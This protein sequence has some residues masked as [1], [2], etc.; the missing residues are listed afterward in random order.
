MGL[1][2]TTKRPARRSDWEHDLGLTATWLHLREEIKVNN[3]TWVLE[4]DF[5]DE[6]ANA[7]CKP[8]AIIISA[9][10]YTEFI[11]YGGCYSAETLRNKFE[12]WSHLDWRLY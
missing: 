11:E 5:D 1:S 9:D 10:G 12:S 8:D 3:Q 2:K 6:I 4:D 7:V